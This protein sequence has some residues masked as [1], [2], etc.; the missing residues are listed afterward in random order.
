MRVSI[1]VE[2]LAIDEAAAL[3]E[4]VRDL[5]KMKVGDGARAVAATVKKDIPP[6]TTGTAGRIAPTPAVKALID[7]AGASWAD[8]PGTGKEGRITQADV[9]KY[10]KKF[11]AP[12]TLAV[13]ASE[14]NGDNVTVAPTLENAR[15]ALKALHA[16]KAMPAAMELLAKFNVPKVGDLPAESFGAFIDAANAAAAEE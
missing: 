3:V 11:E 5:K 2:D 15:E 4:G 6:A 16:A 10:L 14:E 7:E 8:I 13:P 1:Y 12:A 9:K